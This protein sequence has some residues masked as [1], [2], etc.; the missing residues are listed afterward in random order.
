MMS[1][2]IVSQVLLWLVAVAFAV[3]GI[4]LARQIGILHERV[5]PVGAL[6]TA[7]GPAVGGPAPQLR[8]AAESGRA[9]EIG[10]PRH[11]PRDL[12]LLFVS[13]NCPICRKLIPVARAVA[14]AERLELLFV[15]DADNAER[16]I[17]QS[18][19]AITPDT[20]VNSAEIGM[21]FGVDRLPYAVLLNAAG[22]IAA[23]GLVN[24]REH[25][26]SLAVA[27]ELGVTSLQSYLHGHAVAAE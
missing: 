20:L 1:I 9:I 4:A 19:Y 11:D 15:S 22:V 24:T 10:L 23:K 3:I 18:H 21:R 25:L 27:R 8:L 5:A 13:L 12:L 2:L 14:Q 26:E 17:L 16:A 6:T 7:S